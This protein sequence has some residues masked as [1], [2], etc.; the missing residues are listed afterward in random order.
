MAEVIRVSMP[1]AEQLLIIGGALVVGFAV[2]WW[3]AR[4]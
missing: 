2:G 3:T 4:R 1:L